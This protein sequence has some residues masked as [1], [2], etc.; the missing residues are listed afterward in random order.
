MMDSQPAVRRGSV[1]HEAAKQLFDFQV[2]G[3]PHPNQYALPNSN[4]GSPLRA[5]ERR[6]IQ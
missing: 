1:E 2:P 4:F 5:N 6:S 3:S